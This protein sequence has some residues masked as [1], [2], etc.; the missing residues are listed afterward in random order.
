MVRLYLSNSKDKSL[1]VICLLILIFS[2]NVQA[3]ELAKHF[4][5]EG[6]KKV[7]NE[8]GV[9]VHSQKA[10]NSKIVG[11]K[12][13]AVLNA[14]LENVLQ[15]LRD[16]EGTVGWA[17]NLVE[18][19]TITNDSDV[20]A[21]TYN[22]NDLPWPA[23]DR[24]MVLINELRLDR[25]NKLLVV[26]THSVEHSDYPEMDNAVRALMPYGTLEFK[27]VEGSKAWVRMT[28]LVDPRG[29]IPVWLVNMLQKRLPL[30]FLKALE[31]ESQLKKP[32]NLPGVKKLISELDKL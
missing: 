11:F 8:D 31:K 3:D 22:N 2:Q 21:I 13:E 9:L 32:E 24:D 15:V 5:P 30:Q 17:P 27:R 23:A 10:H 7:Y 28:I 6:W 12:A 29:A 19:K 26:D 18:K 1:K 4:S 25:E 14:T 16:V 20:K